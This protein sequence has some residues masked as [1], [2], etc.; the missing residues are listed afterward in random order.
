MFDHNGISDYG[1]VDHF[2]CPRF[3]YGAMS[4]LLHDYAGFRFRRILSE[5]G[6][7]HA[8]LFADGKRRWVVA[9]APQGKTRIRVGSD[10]QH[11]SVLDVMGNRRDLR[12]PGQVTLTVTDYPTTVLLD[13]ATRVDV[14]KLPS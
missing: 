1:F 14:V 5:D 4:A 8:Y 12:A 7:L 9:F 11:A 3:V 13:G 6:D 10:A 2:F